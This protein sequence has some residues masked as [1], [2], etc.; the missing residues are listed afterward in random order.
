MLSFS[1]LIYDASY[2]DVEAAHSDRQADD[3]LVLDVLYLLA[4]VYQFSDSSHY[5][6]FSQFAFLY[7]LVQCSSVE[8]LSEVVY[9]DIICL[10]DQ[11]ILDLAV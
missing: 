8:C 9:Y 2:R 3:P 11:V 6:V 1:S 10:K 7:E 5:I 4:A